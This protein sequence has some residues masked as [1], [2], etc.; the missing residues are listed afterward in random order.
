M[1]SYNFLNLIENCNEVKCTWSYFE[2]KNAS[3]YNFFV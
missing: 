3:F 1:E 2:A